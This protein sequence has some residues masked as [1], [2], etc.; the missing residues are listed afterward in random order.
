MS[1]AV[2]DRG[3]G[4]GDVGRGLLLRGR[5]ALTKSCWLIGVGL[6]QRLVALG[7]RRGLGQVGLGPGVERSLGPTISIDIDIPEGLPNIRADLNQLEA[8]LLNL[9]VNSRDAMPHGG[10]IR[11]AARV[12]E[13]DPVMGAKALNGHCLVL[14]VSDTGEGMD[15]ETARRAM[16]PFFTT[17]GVGKGTGLGLSMVHGMAEQLGGRMQLKREG[18]RHHRSGLAAADAGSRRHSADRGRRYGAGPAI[19]CDDDCGG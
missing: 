4:G 11:I 15:P 16:E 2:C 9:A 13:T 3:L 18:Q 1:C 19:A 14:S 5:R 10:T 7:L 6:A 17:K 12:M 8:G